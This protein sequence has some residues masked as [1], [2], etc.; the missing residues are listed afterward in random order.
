RRFTCGRST[1]TPVPPSGAPSKRT[2]SDAASSSACFRT[3]VAISVLDGTQS[4]STQEPP[5]PLR[6]TT[7]TSAPSCAATSAA[8]YP[9]GPPPM[10]T[11]LATNPVPPYRGDRADQ[12][13]EH[14]GPPAPGRLRSWITL[15]CRACLR[16][17][18]QQHGSQA[19]GPARPALA[20]ARHR[21]AA[22]LAA[23]VRRRGQRL[24]GR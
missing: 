19:D 7:V 4:V 17:L 14:A 20:D 22:G 5:G 12:A 18:R 13:P 15:G 6:S 1:R 10:I 21:L 3:E 9:P 2:P 24:G 23:D 8:S 16:R 11:V